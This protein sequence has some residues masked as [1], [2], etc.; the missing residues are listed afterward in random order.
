MS[1]YRHILFIKPSSLGDIVHAMPTLAALRR[2]HPSA[3]VT[4]LV[5]RQWAGL[6]ERIDGVDRVWA[7][8]PGV[9]GWLSQV[10][11]LRAEH[12]DVAV[13][14]QGLFRSAV[15]GWLSGAPHRV[16]FANA[17]EGS[18]WW[19][20]QSVAVPTAEMHA[21]DRYLLVAK[22]M[23][24]EH[25]GAAEFRFR[26][27]QSDSDEVARLLGRAGVG[28]GT[29]WVAMNV[30]ARWPTKRWPA[31]S[32]AAVADQLNEG[33]FGPV[34]FIGGPEDRPVINVVSGMMK[35]R[36]INIAGAPAVGLLP[37]LLN[38]AA[39]LITND[40]GPMHIAAA[41]ATPVLALFGPTSQVRTG[42]YGTGHCVLT[43]EVPC[44]PCFSRS[45]RNQ[46]H[47]ECLTNIMPEQAVLAAK[48]QLAARMAPR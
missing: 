16:G 42:P 7:V 37:A 15:M 29:N 6:V 45:C 20:N 11:S 47:L 3:R 26:I 12:F 28:P 22:A 44:R 9:K 2:G 34:L 35:T 43:S 8:D 41:V 4:W 40:S 21:V 18:P 27:P 32:F 5:K 14:L 31:A 17:R 38:Q 25:P 24:A 19:Y 33:G 30:S 13:D 1:D 48:A 36:A 10:P 39:I 23:G 46:V